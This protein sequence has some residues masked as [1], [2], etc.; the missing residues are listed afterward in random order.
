MGE[1]DLNTSCTRHRDRQPTTV[2]R[3]TKMASILVTSISKGIGRATALVLGRAGRTAYTTMRLWAVCT[4]LAGVVLAGGVA[5]AKAALTSSGVVPA[6]AALT[7]DCPIH[8]Y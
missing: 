5:P 4:V 1:G 3:E 2:R 6:R 8:F 7:S